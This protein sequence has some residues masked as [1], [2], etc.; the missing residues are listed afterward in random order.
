MSLEQG[1]MESVRFIEDEIRHYSD[2]EY[3][4]FKFVLAFVW[5]STYSEFTPYAKYWGNEMKR[6]ENK[7]DKV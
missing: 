7:G 4:R 3:A 5:S 6:L 1:A 2:Y